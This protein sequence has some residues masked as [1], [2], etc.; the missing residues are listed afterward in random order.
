L[1][2]E[3]A[4]KLLPRLLV[5][6]ASTIFNCSRRMAVTSHNAFAFWQMLDIKAWQNFM[7]TARPRSRN[8]NIML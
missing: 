8:P 1:L 2:I 4:L 5:M 7:K 6:E 3:K